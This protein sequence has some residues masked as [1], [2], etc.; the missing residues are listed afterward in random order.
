[1]KKNETIIQSRSPWTLHS[2]KKLVQISSFSW[3]PK[4]SLTVPG[5]KSFSNRA[6]IIAAC[7]KGKSKLNGL[8]KSDDTFWCIDALKKV[9]V[10]FIDIQ[11]S[12][13]VNGVNNSFKTPKDELFIGAAGTIAR[14]LPGALAA[15]EGIE[16]KMEA[17]HTLS[18]RPVAPLL[19]A[20]GK[21]GVTIE[22]LKGADKFPIRVM[23]SGL[24]GGTIYLP[25]DVSSQYLSG[26]L[27]CSPLA[28]NPVTIKL[29]TS[30][31]Q[32]RYVEMTILA[33]KHFG[34]NVSVSSNF[35][36]FNVTPQRYQGCHYNIE[37][38]VSSAGYFFALAAIN[39]TSVTITNLNNKTSQPDIMLLDVLERMGCKVEKSPSSITIEGTENLK[40]GFS[41]SLK[42]FSDQTLTLG[43][44]AAFADL[45]IEIT[46]VAHIRKHECDRLSALAE[47]LRRIGI[48]TELTESS[49]KIFPGQPKAANI[50]THHDHRVAMAFSIIGSK[51][52]GI[53]IENPSCVAKTFPNF[54]EKLQ[55]VGY[56]IEFS[57]KEA[58][59]G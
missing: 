16:F 3:T 7:A 34:V 9:G 45:P 6:L 10:N 48:V 1:M 51:C 36:E 53:I 46:D 37:A 25:A 54:Y 15:T 22:S 28:K 39:S 41:V 42:D 31:V 14:F 38:D 11:S 13:E 58:S 27:I 57:K 4:I 52:P 49:I 24:I 43:C 33:M 5:S 26:L 32:P 21:M 18:K 8:L 59:D 19:Q 23:S 2:D 47:G 29:T 20:L 12:L 56:S 55:E 50:P 35:K 40:G 30:I 17:D 44:I